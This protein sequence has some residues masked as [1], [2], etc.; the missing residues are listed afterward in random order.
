MDFKVET[1]LKA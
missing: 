1:I